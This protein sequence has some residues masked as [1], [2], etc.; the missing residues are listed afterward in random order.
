MGHPILTNARAA[1][2]FLTRIPVGDAVLDPGRAVP[3]FPIVGAAVGLIVAGVYA[4][5]LALVA[6]LPAA[7][8][9][10]AVGVAITGA[11]HED[12]LADLADATGGWDQESARRILKDPTHGTYGVSALLLSIT[13]RVAALSAL[14]RGAALAVLP[15]AHALGRGAALAL[16][17]VR[18]NDRD[19]GLAATFGAARVGAPVAAALLIATLSL[20]G[21]MPAAAALAALAA[22]A[23]A[24]VA[25]R[26][27][28]VVNGDA[29]GAAEQGGEALVLLLGAAALHHALPWWR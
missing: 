17:A 6:P 13:V 23:A 24:F 25:R 10:I 12:G 22:A 14:D 7:A 11:F 9:A 20:A 1:V 26:R 16:L 15:A 4:G 19:E 8:V 2:G 27:L 28:G 3:W 29:L 5:A 21:W 18:R